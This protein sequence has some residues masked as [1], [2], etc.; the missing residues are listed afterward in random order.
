M[1]K[2]C[3]NSIKIG[4]HSPFG[5]RFPIEF[6]AFFQKKLDRPNEQATRALA[7]SLHARKHTSDLFLKR[8]CMSSTPNPLFRHNYL[9][10]TPCLLS[11]WNEFL[12]ICRMFMTLADFRQSY[13]KTATC[14]GWG[15]FLDSIRWH[16]F[17]WHGWSNPTFE[18][19]INKQSIM[20][21]V[22]LT[23]SSRIF[24]AYT[25]PM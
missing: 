13:C 3:L 16:S 17:H 9:L 24:T 6:E 23:N 22:K 8:V 11:K 14:L 12:S 15:M 2:H 5:P 10:L 7:Y 20:T 1:V 19:L 18:S 25:M 21:S 4:M